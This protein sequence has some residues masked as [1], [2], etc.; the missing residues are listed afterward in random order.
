[1]TSK[2]SEIQALFKG[3]LEGGGGEEEGGKEGQAER[4]KGW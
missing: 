3:K 1:M 2:T 4:G